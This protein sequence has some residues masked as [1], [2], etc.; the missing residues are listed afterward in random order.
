[1]GF[2]WII[3]AAVVGLQ[4]HVNLEMDIHALYTLS[5]G[6]IIVGGKEGRICYLKNILT[7]KNPEK[8]CVIAGD[9]LIT[10]LS[11]HDARGVAVGEG[12]TIF[13]SSDKGFTWHNVRS[14]VFYHLL[15]VEFAD[16]NRVFAVG[17][18]GTIIVSDDGGHTW[19]D[20]SL[21]KEY[22]Q[23][24]WTLPVLSRLLMDP[25]TGK[26]YQKG[27]ELPRDVLSRLTKKV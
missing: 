22:S 4:A 25:D 8:R 26:V 1:M 21:E 7:S 20:M 17:D 15:D 18:W 2:G 13:V 14:P 3:L 6:E 10:S 23:D 11:F 5:S 12:G 16:E 27:E 9:Q 19:K 24:I